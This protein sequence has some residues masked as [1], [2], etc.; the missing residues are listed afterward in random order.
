[1]SSMYPHPDVRGRSPSLVGLNVA[2]D[3]ILALRRVYF[4]EGEWVN[5]RI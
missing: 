3:L 1:M 2:E 4:V 5:G